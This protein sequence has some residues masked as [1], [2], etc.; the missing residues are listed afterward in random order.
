M[1]DGIQSRLLSNFS[2]GYGVYPV[3]TPVLQCY[4][5][6]EYKETQLLSSKIYGP[7]IWEQ[8]LASLAE[9]TKF[10]FSQDRITGDYSLTMQGP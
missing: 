5:A 6:S 2:V 7:L 4:L 1:C 9:E 8:D 10:L 3:F